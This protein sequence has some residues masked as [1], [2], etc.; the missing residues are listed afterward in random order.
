MRLR[1]CEGLLNLAFRLDVSR[2][3]AF[4]T[5]SRCDHLELPGT[6]STPHSTY[7]PSAGRFDSIAVALR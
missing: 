1:I 3:D 5:S 7:S 2:C 6:A 4:D